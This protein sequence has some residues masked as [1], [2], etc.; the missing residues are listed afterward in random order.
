MRVLVVSN[1]F[2]PGFIGGYELMAHDVAAGLATRGHAVRVLASN[3]FIDDDATIKNVEVVRTLQCTSPSHELETSD[4]FSRV[5][6]SFFNIRTLGMHLREFKPHAVICFNLYGLGSVSIIQYLEAIGCPLVLFLADDYFLEI[7]AHSVQRQLYKSHFGRLEFGRSTRP[8]FVSNLLSR[9]I[10]KTLGLQVADVPVVSGWTLTAQDSQTV[11]SRPTRGSGAPFRFVYCS[12]LYPHKGYEKLLPAAKS[13]IKAGAGNF[14][15]DVYGPGNSVQFLRKIAASNLTDRIFVKGPVSRSVLIGHLSEYDALLFP[16][17]D[18]EP[19]GQVAAEAA[20]QGC[21][22]IMTAGIG[23]AEWFLNEVDCFKITQ[24]WK[25]LYSAMRKCMAMTENELSIMRRNALALAARY[26]DFEKHLADIISITEDAVHAAPN[27]NSYRNTRQVEVSFLALSH[28]LR[29]RSDVCNLKGA[30]ADKIKEKNKD[31]RKVI[32]VTC[33]NYHEYIGAALNSVVSQTV[34]FDSI[35]IVN[36]GSTD[37]SLEVIKAFSEKHNNIEVIDK[38]NGGQLS[39]LNSVVNLIRHDDCVFLLD[40]DDFY[41]SDYVENVLGVWDC[42][43]VPYFFGDLKTFTD[44]DEA[45]A[46]CR[47]QDEGPWI[48]D[49]SRYLTA[50]RFVY[51]GRPTSCQAVTGE[52]FLNVFP[53]HKDDDWRICAD[54]VLVFGSSLKGFRKM[55]DPSIRIGYRVHDK[56]N[57]HRTPRE[58]MVAANKDADFTRACNALCEHCLDGG[59]SPL[60][61]IKYLIP[62]YRE[63]FALSPRLRD[64]LIVGSTPK[65]WTEELARGAERWIR[66]LWNRAPARLRELMRGFVRGLGSRPLTLKPSGHERRGWW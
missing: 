65:L 48:I 49:K 30:E 46:T 42:D 61:K 23:A 11:P 66:P 50:M 40:A 12:G 28:L 27:V 1:I 33:Y 34:P 22:P 29:E 25:S 26:F 43:N 44:T 14:T 32:I 36:D 64:R 4:I 21:I 9:R 60:Y 31:R 3:Y 55:Y 10:G 39:C 16:T 15:I 8:I 62:Y 47:I 6:F 59:R 13:L 58:K 17:H 53:Y 56:N 37:G 19:F 54:A 51:V 57:Y 5:F 20:S 24:S 38:P 63:H 7:D 2:P 35:I 18:L 45:P 41:P 52:V